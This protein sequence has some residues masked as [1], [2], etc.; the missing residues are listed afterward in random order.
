MLHP[1]EQKA[2]D[3]I[4]Q[5]IAD[6]GGVSPSFREIMRGL[7]W[8]SLGKI[9]ATMDALERAQVLRRIPGRRRAIELAGSGNLIPIFDADTLEL[10]GYLP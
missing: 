6:S 2:Y 5:Y 9:Q 4:R 1:S 7:G 8:R 10:R 3:F